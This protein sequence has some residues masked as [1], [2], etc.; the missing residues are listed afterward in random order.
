M[1]ARGG[2][3]QKWGVMIPTRSILPVLAAAA[4]AIQEL[5]AAE[6]PDLPVLVRET[7][8][9]GASRWKTTDGGAWRTG[10]DGGRSVF[11]LTK[12]VSDYQPPHR[13]PHNIAL[14]E[15]FEVGDFV[16]EA[17]VRT[18]E[19]EYAHRSLCLFFGYRDPEHFYYVHFG[20]KADDHA[21]QVFIVDGAPRTKISTRTTEGTPW[22]DGTWHRVKIVRTV[23]DGRIE[24]FFDDM[25]E[26]VMTATDKTFT[27]GR[28][29]IGSFDDRGMW[30]EVVLRG[31]AANGGERP[32]GTTR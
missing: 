3:V 10:E 7:F 17:V 22:K 26:P 2:R 9:E 16:L 32:G 12:K 28:V 4:A 30:D 21:N 20:Q 29:G 11:E 23:D 24:V 31:R 14:L 18:T 5:P 6:D 13:S 8:D 15:G 1:D 19:P 27:A 25:K